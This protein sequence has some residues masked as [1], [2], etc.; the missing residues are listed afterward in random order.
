MGFAARAWELWAASAPM[1]GPPEELAAVGEQCYPAG[2]KSTRWPLDRR[3]ASGF[4]VSALL[5]S[6][7]SRGR[8]RGRG[9]AARRG[10]PRRRRR[11]DGAL[12]PR[13]GRG[14]AAPRPRRERD[15]EPG[16]GGSPPA[17][18]AGSQAGER[19]WEGARSR[20]RLAWVSAGGLP[21]S[22]PSSCRFSVQR[23]PALPR[24]S[25]LTRL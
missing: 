23:G 11:E 12:L 7:A 16:A 15:G 19:G 8:G 9:S 25:Q 21:F 5:A 20:C 4:C 22:F 1:E 13:G 10:R 3:F 6:Q 18:R 24:G 17:F 2:A 14:R